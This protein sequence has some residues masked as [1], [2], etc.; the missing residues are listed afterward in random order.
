MRI[1]RNELLLVVGLTAALAV[2]FSGPM[3]GMLE[4]STG[5]EVAHRLSLLPGLALMAA[6]LLVYVQSKRRGLEMQA[7]AVA[8][9]AR[10]SQVHAN[11]LKRLVAFWETLTQ[12]LDLDAIREAARHYLPEITGSPDG[13][14]VTGAKGDWKCIVG[15]ATVRTRY[16]ETKVTDLALEALDRAEIPPAPDGTDLEGQ[17]CFPM[18][19]AGATFGVLGVPAAARSLTDARRHLVGAAAALLGVSVRGASL[20]QDLRENSL[21]DSLTGCMTR[22]HAMEVLI[23]ELKRA[24]RSRLPVSLILLD[25]DYFKSINDRYGHL[26]GDAVLTAVGARMRA[27]LR[28]SDLKCRYGGEEFM[29]LLPE[30]SIEGATHVAESLRRDISELEIPWEGQ[31]IRVTSSFGVATGRPNE[32]DPTPII[33][34]AD[35]ALYRA[36]RDGRNCIRVAEDTD[37]VTS[38]SQ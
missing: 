29:V 8:E 16:G 35:E 26:C 14:V 33:A 6:A 5:P 34:R 21:R 10:L 19:A 27:T 9:Q 37:T 3:T 17:I 12:S 38:D 4:A 20:L 22:G 32:L 1:G 24:R 23:A 15:P 11:E 36:K 30:T 28:F 13:W 25:I 2:T 7:A 18:M 31:D